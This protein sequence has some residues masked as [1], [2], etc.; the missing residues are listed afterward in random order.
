MR[1]FLREP[2]LHF[3]LLGAALF[4]AYAMVSKRSGAEPGRIVITRGQVESLALG[5]AKTWQRSPTADE[6]A[7][8]VRERI[9]EEV[10]YREGMALGLDQD[11]TVIR[12]RLRQ[13]MEF[14][15][16]DRAA[17]AEPSDADLTAYLAAHPDSFRVEPAFTFSQVYL[18]PG[19]HGANLARD[20]EALL[21]RLRRGDAKDE[22]SSLGDPF[23]LERRFTAIPEN[24]VAKQFGAAFATALKGLAPGRWE[25][26]IE[27]GFGVHLVRVSERT[28]GHVPALADVRDAVRREWINA[29]RVEANEQTYQEL[30]KRY[31]VTVDLPGLPA[32]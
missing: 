19:K 16:E 5:F 27:S 14:I 29:R 15:S 25:G 3:L 1:R 17:P 23:L 12:R 13:K 24:V 32:Q 8:L 9:R 2:L 22:W 26:P 18:D 28:E 30:L 21:T 31:E 11:D 10:Y 6:L 7:G 4:A 20:A